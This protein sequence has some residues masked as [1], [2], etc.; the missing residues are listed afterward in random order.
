[1]AKNKKKEGAKRRSKA[2]KKAKKKR[3]LRLVKSSPASKPLV[4]NRAGLPHLGAPEG[5]RSISFSQGMMEYAKPLME[6]VEGNEEDFQEVMD[7]AM[8][9]WNYALSL[10]KG[11]TDKTIENDIVAALKSCFHLNQSQAE[12]F[13]TRMIERRSYLFPPDK[14]PKSSPF[15]FIRKEIRHIIMPFDY[16]SLDLSD[17]IIPPDKKDKA[18]VDKINRLDS[19]LSAGID[20]A[21]YEGDFF[22]LKDE[23]QTRFEKWLT[24]KGLKDDPQD[25]SFC[26]LTFLD[27]VY[28]YGHDDIVVLKSI[29]SMYLFE[30]FEDFL[31]RKMMVE[32]NEYTY[33][34]PTLK[35]FYEFLYEKG[36]VDNLEETVNEIHR[37]EPY[38]IE[39]LRK[40]FS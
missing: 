25:F 13:F 12:A 26:L 24:E 3:R 38:F 5:F 15:M 11:Q 35:L 1:M 21:K 34:P 27:F 10:E 28:G 6:L 39:V 36:Y 16:D 19:Q 32:P 29:P 20:Y 2:R 22:A 14:Q 23:C 33:W 31:L 37:I 17:E 8:V 40:Q 30:F 9:L 4:I 7:A 18:L